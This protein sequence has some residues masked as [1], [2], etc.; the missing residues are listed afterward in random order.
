MLLVTLATT[1]LVRRRVKQMGH[2]QAIRL[3]VAFTVAM[4]IG[5]VG[6]GLAGNWPVALAMYGAVAVARRTSQ[7]IFMAW[8]NRGLDPKVRATVLSTFGQMDAVGQTVAGPPI[9]AFATRFGLRA[10]FVLI[11]ALLSP[12]LVFYGRAWRQGK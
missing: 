3:L 4:I 12:A 6:F 11:G 1:E 8:I 9:G 10:V 2:R 5:L 7:P